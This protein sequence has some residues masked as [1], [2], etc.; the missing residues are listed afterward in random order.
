M[1]NRLMKDIHISHPRKTLR[2][3]PA[4]YVVLGLGWVLLLCAPFPVHSSSPDFDGDGVVAFSDF[5]LFASA[6]GTTDVLYDL[7]GN[8]TVDFGDFIQFAT[9]FG[10]SAGPDRILSTL[11]TGHPRLFLKTAD[12]D[13][14]KQRWETDTALKKVI[15]DVI[16]RANKDLARSALVHELRGPRLLHVSRDCLNR[17]YNLGVAFRWTGQPEYLD[18]AR[19]N[20]LTVAAFPDWNPSHFLDVA[21]MSHAVGVGYDWLYDHLSEGDR[22]TIRQ[23]LIRH[24]LQPGVDAYNGEGPSKWWVNSEHNWNQVCNGGLIVGAL[25]IAETDPQYAE[26]ILPEALESLPRALKTYAPDGAWGEGPGYWH[27]ATRYTAYGLDALY[28]ALGRDFGLSHS[29]GLEHSAHFP[30]QAAGP[31][32][33]YLN[34]ADSGERSRRRPMGCS[35]WLAGMFDD[36]FIRATEHELLRTQQATAHHL[37]WYEPPADVPLDSPLDVLYRGPVP[38]ALFRSGWDDADALFA[39][40]KAGYNQVNHAHLDLGNFELDAL[41][42]RWARDLGSD[43]YNLENY[44]Q[45]G[46]DGGRW[47]YYRLNS[48]SH[49]VPLLDRK[50][51]DP[52]GTSRIVS[53]RPGGDRP[54]AVIDLSDAYHDG[55]RITRGLTLV[56]NRRDLLVQDDYDLS[57]RHFLTWGMTTDAE[58]E[59]VSEKEALLTLDGR[60]LRAYILSPEGS[61]FWARSAERQPPEKPNTGVSRLVVETIMYTQTSVAVLL[62]PEW[63]PGRVPDVPDV[64]PVTT[65]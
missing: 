5:I 28:T 13:S 21:E 24:G 12:V 35:F 64:V 45:K 4:F 56:N 11:D 7:D 1:V 2:L 50:G 38:V 22:N 51:Q 48:E 10:Q 49:N 3:I 55:G 27:Y 20:L 57:R 25:A 32:G 18:A 52:E 43:D 63:D 16:V 9:A 8:G 17:I 53:F 44:W 60:R 61:R 15:S 39:G 41:G 62:A 65:W 42:V 31:T 36:D 47:T 37:V 59:L 26:T 58:I 29:Q 33:F 14:L 46:P 40:I 19:S 6:F 34:Y 30:V 54:H 23:A